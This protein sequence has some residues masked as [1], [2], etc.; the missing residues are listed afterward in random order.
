MLMN[1]VRQHRAGARPIGDASETV[2]KHVISG[3]PEDPGERKNQRP[4][5]APEHNPDP[6]AATK[7]N[8]PRD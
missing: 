4:G 8:A 3:Q 6:G 1:L 2:R 7:D 5:H